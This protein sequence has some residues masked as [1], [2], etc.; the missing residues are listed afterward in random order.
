MLFYPRGK[1][2]NVSL[3]ES[4]IDNMAALLP[5]ESRLRLF[6]K[7]IQVI[8]H[9]RRAYTVERIHLATSIPKPHVY[10]YLPDSKS[11]RV[12]N[13]ETTAKVIKALLNEGAFEAVLPELDSAETMMRTT[14]RAYFEWK[15]RYRKLDMIPDPLSPPSRDRL[16]RSLPRFRNRY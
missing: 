13:A 6:D 5:P 7:L 4:V 10:R 16:R 2:D 8:G 1:R 15:R 12:P 9:R 3:D 14:H 11:R